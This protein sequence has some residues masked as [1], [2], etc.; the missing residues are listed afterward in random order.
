MKPFLTLLLCFALSV[1]AFSQE[2]L[3]EDNFDD[4]RFQWQRSG[5]LKAIRFVDGQMILKGNSEEDISIVYSDVVVN[6]GKDFLVSAITS[7]KG[8][9]N[10]N[11][12]GMVFSDETRTNDPRHYY[13]MVFPGEG[14]EI[15]YSRSTGYDLRFVEYFPRLNDRSIAPNE[16]ENV[17]LMLRNTGGTWSFY[18]DNQR[19][20][21]KVS[22]GICLTSV[23]FFTMGLREMNVDNMVIRQDGWNDIKL[24]D[25]SQV[26]YEKENLGP[27]INSIAA[28]LLPIISADEETLFLCVQGDTANTGDLNDQDIWYSTK[29]T[30]GTWGKRKNIGFPLNNTNSNFISYLSPDNNTLLVGNRY[31]KRGNLAGDGLSISHRT[32][33][34]WSIPESIEIDDYYNNNNYISVSYS[35]TGMTLILSIEREDTYGCKDLYVSHK[36]SDGTWSRPLNMGPDINTYGDEMSPFLAAD[37]STLYFATYARAGYG[38]YDIFITRRLD[39]SWTSWS[40][41]ENMGPNINTEGGDAYFTISA[42]GEYSYLVSSRN[43]YGDADIFRVRVA[44]VARPKPVALISGKVF[45]QKSSQILEALITYY[46]LETNEEIG[47][48]RS[49]PEDGNYQ[50]ALESGRKYAYLARMAGYYPISENIDLTEMDVYAELKKD[51]YLAPMEVGGRIRLNNIFFEFDKSD[52]LKASVHELDRLVKIMEENPTMTIS[53]EGHTDWIG[54]DAYN[55][56]LSEDR[57]RAVFTYLQEKGLG[58]RAS[59]IGFGEARPVATNDTDEGRAQNRRVEFVILSI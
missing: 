31:D 32:G 43:T 39:N 48:A 28:E 20:W 44:E 6:P 25:E 55:Q 35:P 40:E 11:C 21:S 27:N 36:K 13:F 9:V 52:L 51:L 16:G 4:N 34:G 12:F 2:I 22:P 56:K 50:I 57:A 58:N 59:S 41:P 54:S 46:D 23:G 49:D 18:I 37:N 45:D 26:K 3:Y 14:F 8:G 42:F 24:A 5:S 30:D 1:T 19:V 7:Y 10:Y 15:Y 29:N 47:T 33:D 17:E 38:N 53:I